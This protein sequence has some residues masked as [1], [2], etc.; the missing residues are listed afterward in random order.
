V[1][2]VARSKYDI[3]SLVDDVM[4]QVVVTQQATILLDNFLIVSDI[5]Y[6]AF[7]SKI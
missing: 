5:Q 2:D 6:A 7:L 4:K 3:P 1:F